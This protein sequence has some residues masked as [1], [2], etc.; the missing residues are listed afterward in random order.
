MPCFI[1]LFYC[2]AVKTDLFKILITQNKYESPVK[3][4]TLFSRC[5][6][7]KVKC[8]ALTAPINIDNGILFLHFSTKL[9]ACTGRLNHHLWSLYGCNYGLT[10]YSANGFL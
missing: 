6:W 9:T 4:I 5:R 3:H 1:L 2:A 8:S 7:A 10:D